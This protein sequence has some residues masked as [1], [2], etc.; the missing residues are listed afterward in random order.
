MGEKGQIGL[1]T[2]F[3]AG[4]VFVALFLFIFLYCFKY[5]I[6]MMMIDYYLWNREY[7]IPLALFSTDINTNPD[8]DEKY[9]SSVVVLNKIYYGKYA[10]SD[11]DSEMNKVKGELRDIINEWYG[12]KEESG[13][14]TMIFGN[15]TIMAMPNPCECVPTGPIWCKYYVCKW[16]PECDGGEQ[17]FRDVRGQCCDPTTNVPCNEAHGDVI[18][19]QHLG[20]YPLPIVFNGTDMIANLSFVSNRVRPKPST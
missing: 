20:L 5:H 12:Y 19:V 4:G 10:D 6:T 1:L 2:A 9:E 14:W 13:F 17:E 11:E 18:G 8:G 7:D 3:I 16:A 15:V